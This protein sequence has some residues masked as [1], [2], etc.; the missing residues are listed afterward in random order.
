LR[1]GRDVQHETSSALDARLVRIAAD[2]AC[3]GAGSTR[4]RTR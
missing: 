3:T 1:V 4:L 2:Q